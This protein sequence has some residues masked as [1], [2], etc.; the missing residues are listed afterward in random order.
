MMSK[1][2]LIVLF[3]RAG[4]SAEFHSQDACEVA[5]QS[6]RASNALVSYVACVQG[7]GTGKVTEIK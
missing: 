7:Y 6:V 1:W 2:I 3:A 4:F 5:A